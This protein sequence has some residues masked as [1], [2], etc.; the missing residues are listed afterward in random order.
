MWGTVLRGEQSLRATWH[1]YE[2]PRHHRPE[3]EPLHPAGPPKRN[4]RVRREARHEMPVLPSRALS[5]IGGPPLCSVIS[6]FVAKQFGSD[7]YSRSL[8]LSVVLCY[9][10]LSFDGVTSFVFRWVL[11]PGRFLDSNA[12]WPLSL[13][14]GLG[15]GFLAFDGVIFRVLVLVAVLGFKCCLFFKP[16]D[17]VGS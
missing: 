8:S 14:F 17:R 6:C 15:R 9:G 12:A 3:S 13:P 5:S 4:R 16:A 1:A 7:R 2:L 10:F 11:T